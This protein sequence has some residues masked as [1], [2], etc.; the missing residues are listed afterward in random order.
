[1]KHA[2]ALL[3]LMQAVALSQETLP[4]EIRRTLDTKYPGW[5]LSPVAKQI[6]HWFEEARYAYRPNLVTGDFN[7]DGKRDYVVSINTPDKQSAAIAFIA[8]GGGYEMQ[9]LSTYPT[10]PFTFLLLYQKGEKDFDFKK[11]KP[12]RHPT[13]AVGLMFFTKTPFTFLYRNGKFRKTLAPS[14]EEFDDPI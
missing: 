12:F 11:M 14:D 8:Q 6:E 5:T 7:A 9:L 4:V 10:D 2:F 13:D 1:M 3:F